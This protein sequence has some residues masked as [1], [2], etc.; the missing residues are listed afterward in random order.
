MTSLLNAFGGELTFNFYFIN[1]VLNPG[2]NEF[3]GHYLDDSNYFTFNLAEGVESNLFYSDF[4]V[5]TDTTI[6]PWKD[7]SSVSGILS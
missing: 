7:I 5:E 2:K 4:N 3:V 1:P 6:L